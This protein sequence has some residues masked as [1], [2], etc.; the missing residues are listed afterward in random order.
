MT[1]FAVIGMLHYHAKSCEDSLGRDQFRIILESSEHRLD[2][3]EHQSL[4]V[5][6]T[7]HLTRIFLSIFFIGQQKSL[8]WIDHSASFDPLHFLCPCELLHHCQRMGLHLFEKMV[9]FRMA[10]SPNR[11]LQTQLEAEISV[12]ELQLLV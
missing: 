9:R 8:T 12:H 5:L 6:Q 7:F 1:Q 2:H 11:L 3:F 4:E 10:S